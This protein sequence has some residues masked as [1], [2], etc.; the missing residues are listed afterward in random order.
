MGGVA[1]SAAVTPHNAVMSRAM[2]KMAGRVGIPGPIHLDRNENAYGASEKALAAIRESASEANRY[3]EPLGALREALASRH[4]V[5]AEQIVVGCGSSEVLRMAVTAFLSQGKK[6]ILASPTFEL[7]RQYAQARKATVVEVRLRKNYS[8]DL[9]AILEAART[10]SG[11]VYICNP[12]NPT[13]TLTER[14]ELETFLGN[15]PPAFHAVID[16]AYH[17]YAGSSGAYTSFVDRPA[18]NSRVIVVRTFSKAYGLAGVRVGYAVA[19]VETAKKV[20][21]DGLPFG[22]NRAG[23]MAAIAALGDPQYIDECAKKNADDRQEFFNQVHARM[24]RALNSHT[25][26]VCLNVMRPAAQ[27]LEHYRKYNLLLAPLIP[28]MPT[29]LRISL[30]KPEEMGEFWRVWDVLGSHHMSM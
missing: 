1:A 9:N 28:E 16:E 25:N 30:G 20:G 19:S 6:L 17:H 29:Y 8:H 10:G 3:P 14:K 5:D 26:F 18:E 22:L 24:L 23:V 27:I 13:G 15:L 2:P 21:A 4:A 12:N 7:I 11:L